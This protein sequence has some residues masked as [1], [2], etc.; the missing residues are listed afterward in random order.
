MDDFNGKG[1]LASSEGSPEGIPEERLRLTLRLRQSD[2]GGGWKEDSDS[3]SLREGRLGR[4][5]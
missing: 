5:L 1:C 2:G 3:L 4:E